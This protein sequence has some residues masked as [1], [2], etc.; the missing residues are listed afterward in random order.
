MCQ[1]PWQLSRVPP[2]VALHRPPP[3]CTHLQDQCWALVSRKFVSDPFILYSLFYKILLQEPHLQRFSF[4]GQSLLCKADNTNEWFWRPWKVENPWCRQV[5]LKLL[6][7]C[8]SSFCT[9][10]LA[11]DSGITHALKSVWCLCSETMDAAAKSLQSCPTH[12][13]SFSMHETEK[14]KWSRSVLSDS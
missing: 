14:W 8:T 5:V 3:L 11:G 7:T 9:L 10:F 13:F 4:R 1:E 12:A 6:H 2:R